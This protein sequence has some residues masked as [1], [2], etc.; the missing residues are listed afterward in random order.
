MIEKRV[1]KINNF[2]GHDVNFNFYKI[3]DY[4]KLSAV[5]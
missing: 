1:E 3:S 5:I 4:A 2:F